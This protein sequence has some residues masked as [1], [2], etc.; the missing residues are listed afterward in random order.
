MLGKLSVSKLR[1]ILLLEADFNTLHKIIFNRR[2]LPILKKKNLF[3]HKI[4][5]CN[6]GQ[7]AIHIALN[8]KLIA[9]ISN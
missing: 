1:V 9:D 6:R 8:K 3:P 2:I 7:S 5:R 4:I